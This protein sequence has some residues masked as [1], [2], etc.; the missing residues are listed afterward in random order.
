MVAVKA[1]GIFHDELTA[2]HQTKTRTTLVTEFGLN[3]VEVLRQLFVAAKLLS[4]HIGDDFLAGGLHHKVTA[5]TVLDAQELRAHLFKATGL[6]PQ[7]SR[8]HHRHGHFNGASAIHFLAHD[9]FYFANDAQA[10]RHVVVNTS[11]QAFDHAGAHHQLM[12]DHLGVGRRL[13]QGGN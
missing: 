10:H 2:T 12:T 4:R 13:F 9:G 11:A 7:L 6:L 1:V 8:L 3:L 5:M